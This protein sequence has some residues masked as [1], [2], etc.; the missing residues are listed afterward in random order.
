MLQVQEE[1]IDDD[2]TV[3][4]KTQL[5]LGYIISITC[6]LNPDQSQLLVVCCYLL[7]PWTNCDVVVVDAAAELIP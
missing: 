4:H 5:M 1:E 6:L 7:S 3:G 2:K